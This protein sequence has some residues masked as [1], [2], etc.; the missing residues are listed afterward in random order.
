[1]VVP[2][3]EPPR[4][5]VR[6]GR[7]KRHGNV[8]VPVIALLPCSMGQ[9]DTT[10][11]P[12]AG[13]LRLEELAPR[14]P[15]GSDAQLG[16]AECHEHHKVGNGVGRQVEELDPKIDEESAEEVTDNELEPHLEEAA[17]DHHFSIL[18]SGTHSPVTQW[19]RSLVPGDTSPLVTS[20]S[21]FSPVVSVGRQ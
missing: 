10:K 6:V 15:A 17:E 19:H 21:S 4:V 12:P 20:S 2:D 11:G 7:R 14:R 3:V 13:K 5:A 8:P 9:P 18:R 1:L 16:F